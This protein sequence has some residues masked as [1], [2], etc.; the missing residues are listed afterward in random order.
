MWENNVRSPLLLSAIVAAVLAGAAIAQPGLCTAPEYRQLDFWVGDWDV[1]EASGTTKAAQVRVEK[2]LGGCV[3]LE[4]YEDPTGLRGQ[5]FTT[6]NATLRVWHQTWVTNRGQLLTLDGQ[7]QDGVLVLTGPDQADGLVR[8]LWKQAPDGLRETAARSRD[9]GK[10]WSPWFDLVFRPR[11]NPGPPSAE[12]TIVAALDKEYQAAV[13]RNDAATMDRVLA[14]GFV[15]VTGTGRAYTKAD[16]LAD[17]RSGRVVYEQQDELE[18][19]VRVFGDTAVVTAKLWLK[20]TDQGKAFDHKLWFSDTYVRTAQ[21]WRYVF[22]QSS[23]PLA[24]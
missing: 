6:Y 12:A 21:G 8:G 4:H 9:N 1:F 19:V 2:I 5:S 22:G 23:R 11:A 16:L 10:T 7:W 20:G 3:L 13:K 15:L 17:A 14:D 24:P 18:Q